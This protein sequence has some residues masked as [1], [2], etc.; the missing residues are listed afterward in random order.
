MPSRRQFI[1]ALGACIA[2]PAAAEFRVEISGIGATQVPIVVGNF[3]DEDKAGLGLGAIIRADLQRSGLFRT[4]ESPQALDER[5]PIAGADWRARGADAVVGGSVTRLADGRLDVRYQLVDAVKGEQLLGQS[6]QVLPADLRLA[7][8]RVADEIYLAI[9]GERGV[10][11]TRIAYVVRSGRRH[12]LHVT[13]ADGEGGQVA[14][15]SAEPIISPAWSPDG[16][17]LAY[18]SFETQKAVV[19]VQNVMSGERRQLANFR[20]SNSAPAWSPDGRDLVVT[21][22]TA[23]IAQLFVMPREGGTPRRLTT[24][25]AIDTEAV[26]SPD[27]RLVYFVS[28]RGGGPQIY[29]VGTAGGSPERVTF[30]GAHNISPSISPDGKQMAYV[31]RQGN[32][33]FK[34]ALLDFDAGGGPRLL[35]DTSDDESPSFAPNG[36]LIVYTSRENRRDVLMTTT[37]D[38]K[39]KTRLVSSGADMLEPAWGPFTR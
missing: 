7:A 6:K 21:L 22:S 16:R 3:R 37:L 32:G 20:G 27:G 25:N 13:D 5:T 11:A 8:H 10:F 28:D 18:V 12:T 9:T 4:S 30:A 17:E 26:Y 35:T 33:A 15:A 1:G 38:G 24:S 39:I 34:V 14:L 2:T 29:R 19:W 36:R 23:G 31:A